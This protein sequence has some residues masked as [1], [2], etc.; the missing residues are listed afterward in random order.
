MSWYIFPCWSVKAELSEDK[1]KAENASRDSVVSSMCNVEVD[2]DGERS[3]GE[4]DRGWTDNKESLA[5]SNLVA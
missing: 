1:M 3:G 2:V 5:V 4:A